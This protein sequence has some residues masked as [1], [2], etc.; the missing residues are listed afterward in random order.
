MDSGTGGFQ[1]D[2]LCRSMLRHH[3][4]L[5]VVYDEQKDIATLTPKGTEVS[6]SKAVP[7]YAMEALG[8][9]GGVAP[10]HS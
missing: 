6:K 3:V 7:L 1:G 10:T 9:R 2:G 4:D 8:V 5:Y